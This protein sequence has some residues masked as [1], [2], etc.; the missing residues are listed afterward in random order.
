MDRFDWLIMKKTRGVSHY[1]LAI[2]K[3]VSEGRRKIME[4]QI[5]HHAKYNLQPTILFNE[6]KHNILALVGKA[7]KLKLCKVL[8]I[9]VF[10]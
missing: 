6:S 2:Y 1:R 3:K 8:K 7:N 4:T 10:M 5:F 9:E